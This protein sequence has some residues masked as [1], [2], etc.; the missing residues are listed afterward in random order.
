MLNCELATLEAQIH[1]LRSERDSLAVEHESLARSE[2]E[3]EIRDQEGEQDLQRAVEALRSSKVRVSVVFFCQICRLPLLRLSASVSRMPQKKGKHVCVDVRAAQESLEQARAREAEIA[4]ELAETREQLASCQVQLSQLQSE[5]N[6]ETNALKNE[7]A[8]CSA[9]ALAA[10]AKSVEAMFSKSTRQQAAILQVKFLKSWHSLVRT[11]SSRRTAIAARAV[12]GSGGVYLSGP[13]Q[14][15]ARALLLTDD[16]HHSCALLA[17]QH[18]FDC[19]CLH[20]RLNGN[21]CEND[22]HRLATTHPSEAHGLWPGSRCGFSKCKVSPFGI[23]G[24][25]SSSCDSFGHTCNFFSRL[26][27]DSQHALVARLAC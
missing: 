22:C 12:S 15:V 10:A 2:K 24:W 9:A 19:C 17:A 26:V 27:S 5:R 20:R 21:G 4:Q 3:R 25:R 6:E 18:K 11:L 23:S 1:K 8:K 14:Q 16:L 13:Q 7:L